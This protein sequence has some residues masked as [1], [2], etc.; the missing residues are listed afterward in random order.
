MA[1][2]SSKDLAGAAGSSSFKFWPGEGGAQLHTGEVLEGARDLRDERARFEARAGASTVG[3]IQPVG[4][5][6][7]GVWQQPQ[8]GLGRREWQL[9]RDG[10][11]APCHECT[12]C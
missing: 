2:S 7:V 3:D 10:D 12:C 9:G 11:L 5:D 8:R 1:G 6:H 4:A